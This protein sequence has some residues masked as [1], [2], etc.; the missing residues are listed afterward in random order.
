MRRGAFFAPLYEQGRVVGQVC[1]D[2]NDGAATLL[3]LGDDWAPAIFSETLDHPQPYRRTFVALANERIGEGQ[4]GISHAAIGTS[5]LYGIFPS[6]LSFERGSWMAP[7][8]VV[9]PRSTAGPC[10]R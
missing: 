4:S 3:D 6:F 8:T 9:T 5:R 1:A 7:D 2:K 10:A